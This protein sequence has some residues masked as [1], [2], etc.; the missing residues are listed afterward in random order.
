[1]SLRPQAPPAVPEETRRIARAAFPK[2][3]LC[4]RIAD[5]LGPVYQDSQFA[6]LFPRRGRPAEAPGRLALA[7][8]LQF[9][10]NLSD[11]EAAEAVRGRIDWKY[12]LGLTLSDPGFDH[13]V[14]SEFPL[15]EHASRASP[16]SSPQPDLPANS[17]PVSLLGTG[18]V[19]DPA[20][21]QGTVLNSSGRGTWGEPADSLAHWTCPAPDAGAR[22]P[23][24]RHGRDR[25]VLSRRTAKEAS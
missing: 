25:R 16:H 4:L 6:A 10:E 19:A 18:I 12:A 22:E 8:V 14:L 7:V 21:G 17:P 20:I 1:M 11:R 9:A 24:R 5:A 15:R 23:A 2:G 3:T 13:T